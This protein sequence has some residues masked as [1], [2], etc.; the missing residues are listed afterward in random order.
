M[1]ANVRWSGRY[2]PMTTVWSRI[3]KWSET[4]KKIEKDVKILQLSGKY[5]KTK[6]DEDV[7]KLFRFVFVRLVSRKQTNLARQEK[8]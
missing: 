2:L 1:Q 3:E 8:T 6:F 7:K 4:K 5:S